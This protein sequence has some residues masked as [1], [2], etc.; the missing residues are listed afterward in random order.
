MRGGHRGRRDG[1][2]HEAPLYSCIVAAYMS[3]AGKGLI[4]TARHKFRC[5]V[6]VEEGPNMGK[7]KMCVYNVLPIE[8]EIECGDRR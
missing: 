4:F 5:T 3:T 2:Q 7:L 1:P 6:D 8:G